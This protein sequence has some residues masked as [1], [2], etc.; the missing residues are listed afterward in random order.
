MSTSVVLVS[1]RNKIILF[2]SNSPQLAEH[3]IRIR[4]EKLTAHW[5]QNTP[6]L[7]HPVKELCANAIGI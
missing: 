5:E 7:G 2:V 1:Y 4:L 3:R 6:G